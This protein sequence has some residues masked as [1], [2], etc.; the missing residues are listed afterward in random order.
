MRSEMKAFHFW[1]HLWI[2]TRTKKIGF[3][4][5]YC[6]N[7]GQKRKKKVAFPSTYWRRLVN[8]HCRSR[9]RYSHDVIAYIQYFNLDFISFGE[10]GKSFLSK[11]KENWQW[12]PQCIL[13][14]T[15]TV[16]LESLSPRPRKVGWLRHT[17]HPPQSPGGLQSCTSWRP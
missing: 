1:A 10:D 5:S 15:L 8:C 17:T 7:S 3:S 12:G 13:K 4:K 6:D 9:K 11:I 14:M 2:Y 16:A